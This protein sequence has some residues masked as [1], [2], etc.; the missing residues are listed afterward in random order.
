VINH[1][2][3]L[4]EIERKNYNIVTGNYGHAGAIYF[5]GKKSGLPEPICFNDNFLLWA[6]DSISPTT[7]I[8]IEH[9]IGSID[10]L[11]NKYLEIGQVEDEYFRENGLKVYYCTHPKDSLQNYYSRIT[12]ERKSKYIR[13]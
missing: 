1:H 3:S 4:S 7:L 10:Q 12:K 2:N 5:Y 9:T 11:Y 8:Y 6:P 13:D